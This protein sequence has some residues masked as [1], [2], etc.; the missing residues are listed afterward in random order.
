MM[1]LEQKYNGEITS[2]QNRRTALVTVTRPVQDPLADTL[3]TDY[4][5]LLL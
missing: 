2:K 5:C 3:T 1:R 4:V